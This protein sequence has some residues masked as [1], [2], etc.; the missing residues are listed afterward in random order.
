MAEVDFNKIEE[1]LTSLE[2]K[3]TY[4]PPK[5]SA[6]KIDGKRAY[7]LARDKR[8]FKMKEITSTIHNIKILSYNHPFL[9]FEATVSE[10][11]YIRSLGEIISNR[12]NI[13]GTLSYLERLEE[14]DFK[15]NQERFI[16]PYNHLKS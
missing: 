5:Y 9:T 8:D 2:G 4:L 13:D 12:L 16:N 10:G 14:G 3:I 11:T 6:K 15:F 7:S 1:I